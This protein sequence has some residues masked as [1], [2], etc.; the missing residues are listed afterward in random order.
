MVFVHY[1]VFSESEGTEVKQ[2]ELKP[3]YEFGLLKYTKLFFLF[4]L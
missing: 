1:N 3:N 4:I 2:S